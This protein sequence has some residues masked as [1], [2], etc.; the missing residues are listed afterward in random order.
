[1]KGTSVTVNWTRPWTWVLGLEG[2]G[3]ASSTGFLMLSR[4]KWC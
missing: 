4:E 3:G 2:L 1:M